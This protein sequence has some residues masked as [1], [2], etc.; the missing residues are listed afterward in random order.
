MCLKAS[1]ALSAQKDN[2]VDELKSTGNSGGR[3]VLGLVIL[4]NKNDF[5]LLHDHTRR[6]SL[7]ASASSSTCLTIVHISCNCLQR[8]EGRLMVTDRVEVTKH[9]ACLLGSF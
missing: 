3:L 9:N 7:T 2:S 5:E 4:H 1:T 8:L 6:V